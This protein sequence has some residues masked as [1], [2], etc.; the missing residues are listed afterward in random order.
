M[1]TVSPLVVNSLRLVFWVISEIDRMS[2]TPGY[3]IHRP[4]RPLPSISDRTT[5]IVLE[6]L[7]KNHRKVAAIG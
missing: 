7:P 4:K 5:P 3:P 2:W 6:V 1:L